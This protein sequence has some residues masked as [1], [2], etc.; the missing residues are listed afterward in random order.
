MLT[1]TAID[2]VGIRGDILFAHRVYGFV[3]VSGHISMAMPFTQARCVSV[4]VLSNDVAAVRVRSG[5]T[6]STRER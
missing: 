6:S 4:K 5:A 2:L 3:D 1:A